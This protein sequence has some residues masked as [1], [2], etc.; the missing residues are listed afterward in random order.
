MKKWVN[1]FQED[2]DFLSSNQAIE[3]LRN[4]ELPVD[5]GQKTLIPALLMNR[6]FQVSY[7]EKE[8]IVQLLEEAGKKGYSFLGLTK[9][10][11]PV[12]V[13]V[14]QFR[15]QPV[16]P[17]LDAPPNSLLSIFINTTGYLGKLI[18]QAARISERGDDIETVLND[19]DNFHQTRAVLE[20]FSKEEKHPSGLE[21]KKLIDVMN[22]DPLPE[23][24]DEQIHQMYQTSMD[25]RVP[26]IRK[27]AL[28]DASLYYN[29]PLVE[30]LL[31]K[32]ADPLVKDFWGR[33]FLHI[34]EMIESDELRLIAENLPK[35]QLSQLKNQK[36]GLGR[37]PA[38]IRKWKSVQNYIPSTRNPKENGGWDA[39]ILEKYDSDCDDVDIISYT[40]MGF[41]QFSGRYLSSLKP[42]LIRGGSAHMKELQ[43]LWS[44]EN[45]V[46][47]FQ[48]LPIST[49]DVP[50]AGTFGKEARRLQFKDY[51]PSLKEYAFTGVKPSE[52]AKLFEDF[53]YLGFVNKL[54]NRQV[55]FYQGIAGT[56]APLH[57]HIDAWN[58]L[59]HGKKRWF[60]FPPLQGYYSTKPI[61]EWMENGYH[62]VKPIEFIQ[63][64]GD[65]A[66][67]P[68][69]WGHAVLNLQESVGVA[70]EFTNPYSI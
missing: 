11:Y 5:L 13:H 53:K 3:L 15:L 10:R 59:V 44:K 39:Q 6:Y 66:Y 40:K 55:Q 4:E 27:Y 61:I 45:F 12:F 31:Q 30:L 17:Y 35:A 47:R 1:L 54:A 56:G 41:Q 69:H 42:V 46:K 8:R 57:S 65:I 36:D 25:K 51:H 24:P 20:R 60:V 7:P 26:K 64:A 16:Y 34:A 14:I 21:F 38:D 28:H 58:A 49:G 2:K 23:F 33:N 62:H 19:I 67:I 50:Y 18:K 70:V 37:T 48:D 9:F 29:F 43:G 32:G 52:Y 22:Q 68:K 63:E